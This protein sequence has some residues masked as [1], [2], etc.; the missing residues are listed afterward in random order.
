M[1]KIKIQSFYDGMIEGEE[2]NYNDFLG[3]CP[4][5]LKLE[6]TL[7]TVKDAEDLINF[8]AEV[9]KALLN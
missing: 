8:L 2:N 4:R 6:V 1:E 3:Y 5:P 9:K 7:E